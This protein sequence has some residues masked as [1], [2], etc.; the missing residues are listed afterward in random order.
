MGHNRRR[1]VSSSSSS[2][3]SPSDEDRRSSRNYSRKGRGYETARHA[4]GDIPPGV[5]SSDN[6]NVGLPPQPPPYSAITSMSGPGF[7]LAP[8]GFENQGFMQMPDVQHQGQFAPPAGPPPS[9]PSH[10]LGFPTPDSP[11]HDRGFGSPGS[12][13]TPQQHQQ[14]HARANPP[15]SGYRIPLTTNAPFPGQQQA[16][17]P[18]SKDLDGSPVFV[19]SALLERSVHPCKIVPG[20]NPPC[21]VPYG[22]TE[23][24]HHGRYDL[25]PFD[26]NTMEWVL[27]SAGRIPPGRRPIE[28]G[29]EEHGGKLYHALAQ[30]NS[31]YIPGKTGE[32]LVRHTIHYLILHP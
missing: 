32:H 31:V 3:S 24:E 20:L 15:P 18:V 22:G 26:P 6:R 8:Q 19:G 16:A 17:Q 27:T 9:F 23:T 4:A 13:N 14:L 11:Q 1:S 21:R 7:P 29:Y 12:P 28:G 30:V 2:S 10:S 5:P 25:L